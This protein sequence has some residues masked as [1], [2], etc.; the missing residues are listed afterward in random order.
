MSNTLIFKDKAFKVGDTINISYKIKEGDKERL[1]NF[2]G[3]LLKIRGNS[4]N[5]KTFTTRKVTKSGIGVERIIALASPFLADITIVKK[6]TYR[7]AKLKFLEGL[8]EHKIRHKLYRP[9]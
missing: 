4:E 2:K 1:Q 6:S 3:I 8:A 5:Q 7:K 9:K